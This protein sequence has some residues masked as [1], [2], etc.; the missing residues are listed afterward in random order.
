MADCVCLPRCP[1]FN[2]RMAEKPASANMYKSKYCEGDST[3]CARHIVFLALGSSAVPGD[4]FPNNIERAMSIVTKS[5][6]V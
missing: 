2:D 4:L 5:Q 6:L 1:F 3:N